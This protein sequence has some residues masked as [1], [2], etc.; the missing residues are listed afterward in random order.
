AHS[1]AASHGGG[2]YAGGM[3]SNH[4]GGRYVNPPTANHYRH[5]AHGSQHSRVTPFANRRVSI[6][7]VT[8]VPPSAFAWPSAPQ[9]AFS[10]P[11]PLPTA[12]TA[13]AVVPAPAA[14]S[15]L[16]PPPFR[17]TERDGCQA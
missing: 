8:P 9:P 16:C 2:H 5:W 13:P 7:G 1:G 10:A 12:T 14:A 6:A 15:D 4:R 11:V 3:G 17:M